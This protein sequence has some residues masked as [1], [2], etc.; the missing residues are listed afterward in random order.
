MGRPPRPRSARG[1]GP[2]DGETGAVFVRVGHAGNGDAS[3]F[4][5][6]LGD[7]DGLAVKI[8][9][10]GW[11]IVDRPYVYFRH[12]NG[13]LPLPVPR[14]DGSLELLRPY[15]NLTEPEFHLLITWLAAAAAVRLVSDPHPSRRARIG[16]EHARQ[17]HRA[18][19]R[20]PGRRVAAQAAKR[21][22]A[23]VDRRERLAPG[24]RQLERD[25]ELA[26]R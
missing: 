9:P 1:H 24:V 2:R 10:R 3:A 6:D 12:P 17:D 15:A 20:P 18:P 8:E 14:R 16:Q 25:T 4:Y 5:L 23:H 21:P 22:P 13:F 19:R 11:S 7:R 26:L